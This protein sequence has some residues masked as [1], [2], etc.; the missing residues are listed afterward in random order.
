MQETARCMLF[1][2]TKKNIIYSYLLNKSFLNIYVHTA[3]RS[4]FRHTHTVILECFGVDPNRNFGYRW[5]G[6]GA[7]KNQCKVTHIDSISKEL[8]QLIGLILWDT[9]RNLDDLSTRCTLGDV[10]GSRALLRAGDKSHQGIC[11]IRKKFQGKDSY[12]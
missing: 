2:S 9:L 11:H 4:F 6:R 3:V 12:E 5:G 1:T 10:H 8:K 7:S